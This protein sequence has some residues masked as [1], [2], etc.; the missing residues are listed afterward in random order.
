MTC[1]HV[2]CVS[3]C[4]AS[5]NFYRSLSINAQRYK[6]R[7][8]VIVDSS[9]SLFLSLCVVVCVVQVLMTAL[10]VQTASWARRKQLFWSSD[11]DLPH[12]HAD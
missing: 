10:R 9:L 4:S 11:L 8:S 2:M 5:R 12:V 1:V 7:M 6:L 3:L